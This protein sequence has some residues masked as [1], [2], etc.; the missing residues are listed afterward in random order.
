MKSHGGGAIVNVASEAGLAG[1]PT[2]GV[3]SASKDGV[4]GFT[5]SAA[6]EYT[7]MVIRINAVAPGAI[8]TPMVLR[9][10]QAAQDALMVPQLMHR[11]GTPEESRA[12]LG[13]E[14]RAPV[15]GSGY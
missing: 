10:H 6:G 1:K 7:N 8:A 2:G 12:H 9:Q 11:L 3:Y 13:I 5:R 15:V 4:I 14:T